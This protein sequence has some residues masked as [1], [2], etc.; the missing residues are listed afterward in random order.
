MK[1]LT[2]WGISLNGG[3]CLAG[4]GLGIETRQITVKE[5][6]GPSLT[7][8]RNRKGFEASWLKVFVTATRD[9]QLWMSNGQQG[10]M[11]SFVTLCQSYIKKY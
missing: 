6:R 3:T 1:Q 7:I 8:F 5:L 9:L 2:R 10:Q 4:D 11:I